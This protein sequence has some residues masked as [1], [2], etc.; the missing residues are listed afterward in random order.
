M[1]YKIQVFE[2][3]HLKMYI[4]KTVHDCGDLSHMHLIS[5]TK[6]DIVISYK[7]QNH[8]YSLIQGYDKYNNNNTTCKYF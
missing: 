4:A 7:C 1:I 8:W 5:F 3:M 2:N 6:Y